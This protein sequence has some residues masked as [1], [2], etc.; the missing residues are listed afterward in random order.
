M[1]TE[2]LNDLINTPENE[3]CITIAL[4]T[5][6]YNNDAQQDPLRFKKMIQ[7]ATG[8]LE[9]K[10]YSAQEAEKL[11]NDITQLKDKHNFWLKQQ[12]SLIV[13]VGNGLF[14]YQKLPFKIN[15]QVYV[16]DHFYIKPLI[17]LQQRMGEYHVLALSK[18]NIRLVRIDN[19]TT[20]EVEL[21]DIPTSYEEF[22]KFD[23][24]EKSLSSS[25]TG[26]GNKQYHGTGDAAADDDRYIE[27]FLK[28]VESGVTAYMRKTNSPLLLAGVDRIQSKYMNVNHYKQVVRDKALKG[29]PDK[30][31]QKELQEKSQPIIEQEQ[32]EQIRKEAESSA[33]YTNTDR[34]AR[35]ITQVMKAAKY[36]QIDTLFIEKD[37][38]Q[39]GYFDTE[40]DE[41]ITE[42][43]ASDDLYNWA[44]V[45]ALQNSGTVYILDKQYMPDNAASCALLR[46][47]VSV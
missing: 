3:T 46:Y 45:K 40:K 39:P 36:G 28:Q 26:S 35:D 9:E 19:Q 47:S 12:E 27:E 4:N 10:G 42:N 41:V 43:E 18:N 16:S 13:F 29:N 1:A 33:D 38:E 32:L 34:F 37:S 44:G 17:E 31:S 5:H 20:T 15:E 14:E 23:V 6:R 2:L 22:T 24:Y 21:E 11:L 7:E 25:S 30:L 8:K